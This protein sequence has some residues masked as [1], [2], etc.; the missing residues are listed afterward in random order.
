MSELTPTSSPETLPIKENS[1]PAWH[2]F[3]YLTT[4]LTLGF[5]AS[6]IGSILFQMINASIPNPFEPSSIYTEMSIQGVIKYGIAST[7]IA[8]PLYF[9]LMRFINLLLRRGAISA[10]SSV[11]KWLTYIVLF[12]AASVMLGD[13]VTFVWNALDGDLPL[14]FILKILS[15]LAIAGSIFGF[16][17]WDMRRNIAD[18]STS[19]LSTLFGR[20][21]VGATM[22]ILISGF[23]FI[24]SPAESRDRKIDTQTEAN[25]SQ[26]ESAISEYY[27]R[28][29]KLPESLSDIVIS[30]GRVTYPFFD[31]M[32]KNVSYEPKNDTSFRICGDF[33]RGSLTTSTTETPAFRDVTDSWDHTSGHVCFDREI[34]L[35]PNTQ[36]PVIEEMK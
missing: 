4:F 29:Q 30:S 32:P 26:A 36:T 21:A 5:L 34:S 20:A 28:N 6:G 33:L 22:V 27:Q 15:I 1:Q 3:L 7:L 16:S 24:Q 13:L 17:F 35:K 19:H 23:F 8:G 10:D 9:G 12:I 11:R 18:E 14:R 2:F 25:L 31:T